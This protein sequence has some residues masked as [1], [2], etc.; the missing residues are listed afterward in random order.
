MS[1]SAK[2]L[3]RGG[4]R[5]GIPNKATI[6]FKEAVNNLIEWGTPQFIQWMEQLDTPDKRLDYVLKFA[7]F[8]YPKIARTEHTGKDGAP[9]E[10]MEVTAE[11]RRK[12]LLRLLDAKRS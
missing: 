2:K 9:I 10:T 3:P 12:V 4:S 11:E 6:G 8:A 5:K 7:E 1:G